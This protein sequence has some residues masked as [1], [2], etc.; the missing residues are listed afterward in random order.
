[1]DTGVVVFLHCCHCVAGNPLCLTVPA[2]STLGSTSVAG[3]LGSFSRLWSEVVVMDGD[4]KLPGS[5]V[6]KPIVLLKSFSM[7]S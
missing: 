6:V 7:T 2:F 5:L 4:V 3:G 1:M